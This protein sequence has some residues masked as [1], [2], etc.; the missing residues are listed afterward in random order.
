MAAR[1]Q[2]KKA[3][4]VYPFHPPS[5]EPAETGSFPMVGYIEDCSLTR[6]KLAAF[7]NILLLYRLA[8]AF[9]SDPLRPLSMAAP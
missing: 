9:P 3:P 5:P 7:F 4:Q 1:P 8:D 2:A 6:T